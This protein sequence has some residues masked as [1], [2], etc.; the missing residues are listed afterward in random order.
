MIRFR[1]SREYLSVDEQDIRMMS[2][3]T[4]SKKGSM[5]RFCCRVGVG[6]G[7]HWRIHF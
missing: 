5:D 2:G 1:P 7:R 3:P 6:D 4:L